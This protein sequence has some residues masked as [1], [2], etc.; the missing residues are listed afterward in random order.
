MSVSVTK[1]CNRA[2]QRLGAAR[3]S[4]IT[5]DNRNGRACNTCYDSLRRME[6]RNHNW[7]FSI[8]RVILAP[9]VAAPA[10]GFNYQFPVPA[11]YIKLMKPVLDTGVP[12]PLCDWE[13]EGGNILTNN[14]GDTLD[15]RYVADITDVAK[16][17]PNFFEGLA[18]MMAYQMCEEITQSNSKQQLILADYDRAMTQARKNNAFETVPV[19]GQEGSWTLARL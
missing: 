12:D 17:D 5:D 16:F 3:I 13:Y 19:D 1:L 4:D 11:D 15:F 14:D 18:M 10:F 2:L 6:L 9:L 8:Q 7:R